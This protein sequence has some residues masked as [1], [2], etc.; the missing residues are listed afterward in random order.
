MNNDLQNILNVSDEDSDKLRIKWSNDN[1]SKNLDESDIRI[2]QIILSRLE[3]II[4]LDLDEKS[5]KQFNNSVLAV[6]GLVKKCK[7]LLV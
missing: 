7:K 1:S 4:E 6:E 2:K 3:E 5:K